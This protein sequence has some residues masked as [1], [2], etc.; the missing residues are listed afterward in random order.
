MPP[1]PPPPPAEPEGVTRRAI[2]AV[3]DTASSITETLGSIMNRG[4][5]SDTQG[6]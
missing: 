1:P 5:G 4:G 6:S 2:D 3:K